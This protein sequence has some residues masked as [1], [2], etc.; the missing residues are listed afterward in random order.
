MKPS[1]FPASFTSEPVLESLRGP[2]LTP[3]RG[4]GPLLEQEHALQVSNADNLLFV[5]GPHATDIRRILEDQQGRIAGGIGL[6]EQR[7]ETLP[8]PERFHSLAHHRASSVDGMPAPRETGLAD[9]AHQHLNLQSGLLSLIEHRPEG[10]Q[11]ELLLVAAARNHEEMAWMLTALLN[12]DDT[13]R[14]RVNL[15]IVAALPPTTA[16]ARWENE[17]GAPVVAP[18]DARASLGQLS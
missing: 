8:Y 4:F 6:V 14:D 1:A 2:T 11:P 9:L 10:G 5:A 3:T 16:E 15:P 12:E 7:V 13:V 17:G 18:I